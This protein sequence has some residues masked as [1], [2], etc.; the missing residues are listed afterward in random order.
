MRVRLVTTWGTAC[1]IAK[2]DLRWIHAF[3]HVDRATGH[4]LSGSNLI[5][6]KG[7]HGLLRVCRECARGY[8]RVLQARY[9]REAREA[10]CVS[11]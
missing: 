6:K 3:I 1:G 11:V 4:P 7:R 8:N 9:R 2:E 10:R 5:L